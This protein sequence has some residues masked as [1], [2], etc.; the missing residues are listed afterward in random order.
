MRV[1]LSSGEG[2]R[3]GDRRN[4]SLKLNRLGFTHGREPLGF[5]DDAVTVGS[6]KR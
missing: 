2:D 4:D 3:E 6:D 5:E 1:V